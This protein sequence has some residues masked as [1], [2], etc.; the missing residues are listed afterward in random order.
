MKT[1]HVLRYAS[2]GMATLGLG[3][4]VA[5][6]SSATIEGP[7]GPDSTN[8]V[9]ITNANSA[10]ISNDNELSVS[11]DNMQDATSGDAMVNDN[12]NGGN[13]STGSAHNTSSAT[14]SVTVDNGSACGCVGGVSGGSDTVR[15]GETGPDSHNDASITNANT[16]SLTNT[17]NLTVTNSNNQTATSGSAS[18]THNTNGGSAT[19]GNASNTTTTHTTVSVKN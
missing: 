6:A 8:N 15:I 11:N 4:G 7:T 16:F 18:V 10:T 1:S 2:I 13:A 3:L 17:N 12:T 9:T 5:A 19:T 14:T